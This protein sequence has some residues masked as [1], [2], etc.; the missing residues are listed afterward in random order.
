MRYTYLGYS[1]NITLGQY[2]KMEQNTWQ[3]PWAKNKTQEYINFDQM[4]PVIYHEAST[5]K[6]FFIFC[7]IIPFCDSKAY[8]L[9]CAWY[10]MPQRN[11]EKWFLFERRSASRSDSSNRSNSDHIKFKKLWTCALVLTALQMTI[12]F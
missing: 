3:D 10:S 6:Y 4:E 8:P 11:L 12:F 2:Y 1:K 5:N 7:L 9:N